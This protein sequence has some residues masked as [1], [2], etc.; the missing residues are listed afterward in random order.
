MEWFEYKPL[1]FNLG[2]QAEL[3]EDA[4]GNFVANKSVKLRIRSLGCSATAHWAYGMFTAMMVPGAISVDACGDEPIHL[5]VPKGFI[6]NTY[7]WHYGYDSADATNKFWDLSDPAP[8]IT[9]VGMT[10][11][12]IDR[13]QAQIYPY[14]RCEMISYTGV[15]FITTSNPTSNSSRISTTATSPVSST[16]P[17][18]S[19]SSRLPPLPRRKAAPTTPSCSPRN[20]SNGG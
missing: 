9:P 2:A 5:S 6:E 8:G 16:T 20:I 15:P 12:Y 10:D 11:V 7:V 4:D 1:A 17:A 19:T 13:N 3:N 14:Y 18:E